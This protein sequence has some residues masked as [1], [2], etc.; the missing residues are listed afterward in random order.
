MP[1]KDL[2][3]PQYTKDFRF[4]FIVLGVTCL[5]FILLPLLIPNIVFSIVFWILITLTIIPYSTLFTMQIKSIVF[6]EQQMIIIYP[7]NIKRTVYNHDI[8]EVNTQSIVTTK[9][10]Y[11]VLNS[12]ENCDV[13]IE[14][15]MTFVEQK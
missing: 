4:N 2:F 7:F 11:I 8:L 5:G 10:P 1:N 13:L 3:I 9:K 15:I 12:I 14:K 6:S